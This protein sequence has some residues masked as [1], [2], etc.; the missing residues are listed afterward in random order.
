MASIQCGMMQS[1]SGLLF[2]ALAIPH[3]PFSLADVFEIQSVV[4]H[5][6]I[7]AEIEAVTTAVRTFGI[8][9]PCLIPIDCDTENWSLDLLTKTFGNRDR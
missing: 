2:I 4:N 1:P 9:Q 6:T 7:E 5:L 3:N 8:S